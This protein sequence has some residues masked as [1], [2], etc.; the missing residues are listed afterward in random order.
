MLELDILTVW[1]PDFTVSNPP[2]LNL[3]FYGFF[4]MHWSTSNKVKEKG[5][6]YWVYLFNKHLFKIY[7]VLD[8]AKYLENIQFLILKLSVYDTIK[9]KHSF[10]N[11]R[12]T[13]SSRS[14]CK[15]YIPECILSVPSKVLSHKVLQTPGIEH[16]HTYTYR[17]NSSFHIPTTN[18]HLFLNS[19]FY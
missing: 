5:W 18:K 15:N 10:K 12:Y 13:R 4:L 17:H 9:N 6:K 7:L 2:S 1:T 3:I 19:N 8:L 16:T 14:C 11:P